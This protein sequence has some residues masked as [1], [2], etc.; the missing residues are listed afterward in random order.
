MNKTKHLHTLVDVHTYI[1]KCSIKILIYANTKISAGIPVHTEYRCVIFLFY[2][3][4]IYRYTG[5]FDYTTFEM[6]RRATL[7]QTEPF[8]CCASKHARC[9]RGANIS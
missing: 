2:K 9:D 5:V 4:L 6:L 8:Q 3:F 1:R 7:F